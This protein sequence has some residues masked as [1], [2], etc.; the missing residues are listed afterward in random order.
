MA[1]KKPSSHTP[2]IQKSIGKP[3]VKGH[4]PRRYKGRAQKA[5]REGD[6]ERAH[7]ALM[8]LVANPD[9]PQHVQAAFRILQMDAALAEFPSGLGDTTGMLRALEQLLEPYPEIWRD[10]RDRAVALFE[11]QA[12]QMPEAPQTEDGETSHAPDEI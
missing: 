5:L 12:E 10:L 4:D 3:F 1:G 8:A 7:Q 6:A 9:H 11:S 2:W